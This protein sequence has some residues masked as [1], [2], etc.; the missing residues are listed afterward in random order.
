[1]FAPGAEAGGRAFRRRGDVRK[2]MDMAFAESRL[3]HDDKILTQTPDLVRWGPVVA[4]VII[5][6]G[7]CAPFDSLW[8]GLAYGAEGGWVNANLAWFVVATGAASLFVAGWIAGAL[9]GVRGML[10]GMMNGI[11]AWALLFVVWVAVVLPG[12][13]I[14]TAGLGPG[15]RQGADGVGGVV[16]AGGRFTVESAMWTG[17][18]LLLVGLVLAAAGGILGGRM[19]RPVLM[20][21]ERA[22]E[23]P[24][25][26][27][28]TAQ[29]GDAGSEGRTEAFDTG[30]TR[31]R[32]H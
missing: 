24:T 13:A 10:A 23:Q 1:M 6:L 28:P 25:P 20:A 5:G 26:T 16:G 17:F 14:L 32:S 3:R 4:G 8:L 2:E 31:G 29:A 7:F 27:V 19:R 11:A 12:A 22:G 15:M 18:W 30:G 21:D 9:A